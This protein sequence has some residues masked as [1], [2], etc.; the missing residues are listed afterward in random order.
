MPRLPCKFQIGAVVYHRLDGDGTAGMVLDVRFWG[1]G[2]VIYT[3]QWGL[4]QARSC[5][6]IEL[7]TARNFLPAA[8]DGGNVITET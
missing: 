7:T 4:E 2:G 6:E 1:D 5:Y 8:D 3:V